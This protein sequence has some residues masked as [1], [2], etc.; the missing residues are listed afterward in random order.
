[1]SFAVDYSSVICI[2][3]PMFSGKTQEMIRLLMQYKNAKKSFTTVK[4]TRDNRYTNQSKIYTHLKQWVEA[5][6]VVST[7]LSS[8]VEELK[9]Y[10]VIAIDEGHF[11]SDIDT[12]ANVLASDPSNPRH[13]IISGLHSDYEQKPFASMSRLLACA[14]QIEILTA[15]CERCSKHAPFTVYLRDPKQMPTDKLQTGAEEMYEAR[16]R[17]C[18]N[19]YPLYSKEHSNP[20]SL[21]SSSA[22]PLSVSS[23]S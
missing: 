20:S 7:S 2:A 12:V 1:M 9:K 22:L 5:E 6:Y 18:L 10:E 8:I 4:H 15:V 14:D 11:F 23:T 21:S 3:G 19:T 13:V 16:C 17:S